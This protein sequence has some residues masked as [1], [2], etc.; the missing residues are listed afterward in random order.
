MH[1]FFVETRVTVC[2][3]IEFYKINSDYK[4]VKT[5]IYA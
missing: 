5:K 2:R 3:Y 4:I 1:P